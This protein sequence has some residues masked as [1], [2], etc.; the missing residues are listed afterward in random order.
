MNPIKTAGPSDEQLHASLH[1]FLHQGVLAEEEHTDE[2]TILK[3]LAQITRNAPPPAS[4][5]PPPTPC[6][7]PSS[8]PSGAHAEVV[9][10]SDRPGEDSEHNRTAHARQDA[11]GS[12]PRS[13]VN[14]WRMRQ[15]FFALVLSLVAAA[16]AMAAVMAATNSLPA[17]LTASGAIFGAC[18]QLTLTQMSS[19]K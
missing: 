14:R 5:T 10:C 17:A 16:G 19:R 11:V 12:R 7:A 3:D 6:D 13:R 4:V 8:Q 18:L 15:M 1:A 9:W 2:D